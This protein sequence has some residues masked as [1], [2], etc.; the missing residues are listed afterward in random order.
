MR[1]TEADFLAVLRTLPLHSGARGL[2]DDAARLGNLVLTT[3]TLVEGV[4]Y[5]ASDPPQDVAWKLVASNL[6]DLA[7]KGAMPVGVLLN[8]PLRS[9]PAKAGAQSSGE[10]NRVQPSATSAVAAG[11]RP[12][13]GKEGGEAGAE[14]WDI[15][16]LTGLAAALT[17]F[18]TPLLGGDTVS[19]PAD[20][21]RVMTLTALGDS[22]RAPLRAGAKAGDT[23][24][25]TGN[26]GDAGAGLTIA[27]GTPGPGTLLAA[28]R[29][30]K[31]RIAEGQ[32]LAA[33]V[34]AMMDV[35]DGLLIDAAR[36]AEASGL[37]VAIELAALPLSQDYL[38]FAGADLD[39]HLAAATAGDDYELLFA[40]PAGEEP[41]VGAF[42]VGGFSGGRGLTLTYRGQPVPLPAKLGYSHGA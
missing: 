31:P 11:P 41:S 35:S 42:P 16:F 22:P 37:A 23:L 30:P 15:A 21:P 20:A 27:R 9:S 18:A 40:L 26:L 2:W 14:D 17:H 39:A 1:V 3:D 29:R 25:V 13:P 7:A 36:M 19:L 38:A 32:K 33:I 8:Y 6:S 34:H 5:L 12:S 24:W 10:D 28:Y 4:H